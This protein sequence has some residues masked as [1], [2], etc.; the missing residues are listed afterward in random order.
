[1]AKRKFKVGEKYSV[2]GLREH[3]IIE[4]TKV[5]KNHVHYK[6]IYGNAG[7]VRQF[8]P[9]SDFA[10]S[11][12][13]VSDEAIVIYRDNNKITAFDKTTGKKAIACCNPTDTFDFHTGAKLAFSRLIGEEKSEV[14]QCKPNIVKCDHYEVG[15]KV[16]IRDWDDMKKEF[17]IDK[18]GDIGCT[19]CFCTSMKEFCNKILTINGIDS[20]GDYYVEDEKWSFSRC[21]IAGKVAEEDE[22]PTYY[23][24]TIEILTDC[25]A[26]KKSDIVEIK[27]GL[28]GKNCLFKL[29][30]SRPLKDFA[31]VVR[32]F[33]CEYSNTPVEIKEIKKVHRMAKEGEYVFVI[34]KGASQLNEYEIGDILKIVYADGLRAYY[35]KELSKYLDTNE[36]VILEGYA[37]VKD[38]KPYLRLNNC[39]YGIIGEKTNLVDIIGRHLDVGDVVELYCSVRGKLED[40]V[41]VNVHGRIFVMGVAMEDFSEPIESKCGYKILLKKRA[42]GISDGTM[43]RKIE[44]VK[45]E[46]QE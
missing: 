23:T 9:S 8:A 2:T 18:D 5:D 38:F 33:S 41:V 37:P 21:T 28:F 26:Y 44:Y 30:T 31:D 12:I 13:K 32:Y 40:S 11:L 20:N 10:K 17:G 24:G 27:D 19:P 45:A 3:P 7:F 6:E 15:D 39:N 34:Y 36:Y 22:K 1:M 16:L 14:Q 29:P 35:K 43:V 25:T 4:I 42:K 46:R